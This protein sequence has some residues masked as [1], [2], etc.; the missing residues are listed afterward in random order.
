MDI[1][2]STNLTGTEIT[3][4]VSGL[5]TGAMSYATAAKKMHEAYDRMKDREGYGRDGTSN[6][7]DIISS[8]VAFEKMSERAKKA[9]TGHIKMGEP[10]KKEIRN[11]LDVVMPQI[12]E[13]LI[14][15]LK[16]SFG[17][18]WTGLGIA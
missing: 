12:K 15:S 1:A 4:I 16:K 18:E 11:A 7:I 2:G 3:D 5:A 17:R 14:G 13:N 10:E 6:E 8:G 9:S